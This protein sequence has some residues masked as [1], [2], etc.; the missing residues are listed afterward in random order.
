MIRIVLAGI[1][2]AITISAYGELIY[3]RGNVQQYGKNTTTYTVYNTLNSQIYTQPASTEGFTID[4]YS[5][6]RDIVKGA[7]GKG[8][9]KEL[10]NEKMALIVYCSLQGDIKAIRFIF[11]KDPFLTIQ[12]IEKI[13]TAIMHQKLEITQTASVTGNCVFN[14]PFFFSKMQE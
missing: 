4:N 11:T 2:M 13:E 12:E 6:L 3:K 1:L 9:I 14:I 10:A 8:R 7:L 5:Q